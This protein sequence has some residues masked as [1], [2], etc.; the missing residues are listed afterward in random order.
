V[1]SRLTQAPPVVLP[2]YEQVKVR[3][4]SLQINDS[5]PTMTADPAT[6]PYETMKKRLEAMGLTVADPGQPADASIV[7]T[8]T[9]EALSAE[10][11][12][13]TDQLRGQTYYTGARYTGTAEFGV[14]GLGSK[15]WAVS[16]ELGP[17]N[18]VAIDEESG[19]DPTQAPFISAFYQP[20]VTTLTNVWGPVAFIET[21]TQEDADHIDDVADWL[22]SVADQVTPTLLRML[23][24]AQEADPGSGGTSIGFGA[25][26]YL[27]RI[28][29]H[30]SGS[31]QTRSTIV[32]TLISYLSGDPDQ[33]QE[34]SFLLHLAFQFANPG[35]SGAPLVAL[36]SWGPQ[37]WTKWADSNGY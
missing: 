24:S 1:F 37:E 8:L 13:S 4:V 31:A 11:I 17:S 32:R 25:G 36:D 28:I 34:A 12:G 35:V 21:M 30:G 33:M 2:G 29:E 7:M 16:G 26:T 27:G 9:G 14:P 18:T 23:P 15:Q 10:Y 5:Y 19:L 3:T 22:Y 6:P 20:M